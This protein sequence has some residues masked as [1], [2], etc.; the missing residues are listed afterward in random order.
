MNDGRTNKETGNMTIADAIQES[1]NARFL[2]FPVIASQGFG[3]FITLTIR[4]RLNGRE[5]AESV[6]F[7]T[8][9]DPVL[10]D[11]MN[12]PLDRMITKGN[13]AQHMGMEVF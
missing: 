12:G 4:V 11:G 10:L 13:L 7:P 6:S 9:A 3:E 1:I 2:P 8:P 5:S